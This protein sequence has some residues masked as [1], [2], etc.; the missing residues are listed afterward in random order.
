MSS[1]V[2]RTLLEL[3]FQFDRLFS[4]GI[5][6]VRRKRSNRQPMLASRRTLGAQRQHLLNIVNDY[7]GVH[8]DSQSS[9]NEDRTLRSL[10]SLRF[11]SS[12]CR[13]CMIGCSNRS[14]TNYCSFVHCFVHVPGNLFLGLFG[15]I[16]KVASPEF[17]LE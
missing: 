17:V 8:G 5:R 10:R 4:F 16:D 1:V 14:I 6:P 7:N 15:S 3:F 9:K 2:T 13:H 11:R 12:C